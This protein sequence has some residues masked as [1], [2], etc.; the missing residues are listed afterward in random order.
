MLNVCIL[1]RTNKRCT[2]KMT[3]NKKEQVKKKS[4]V[5]CIHAKWGFLKSSSLEAVFQKLFFT[6]YQQQYNQHKVEVFPWIQIT[7]RNSS[8]RAWIPVLPEPKMSVTPPDIWP[9]LQLHLNSGQLVSCLITAADFSN[10]M[11]FGSW[12]EN[13]LKFRLKMASAITPAPL[14][15]TSTTE[16]SLWVIIGQFVLPGLYIAS[17]S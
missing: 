3:S 15:G 17:K 16:S 1:V 6:I 14:R 2:Q 12:R 4:P 7:H 8:L 9:I 5:S 10:V 13:H 11:W